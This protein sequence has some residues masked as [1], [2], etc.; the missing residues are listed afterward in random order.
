MNKYKDEPLLKIRN[1]NKMFY[2]KNDIVLAVNNV[3]FDLKKG[4]IMGLIGES[5]SG[6][7]TIGNS[8]IR[9][10]ENYSGFVSLDNVIISGKKLSKKNKKFL[11]KNMQM[12]FQ[13]PHASLNPQ[14]NI[15]SIL[16]EPLIINE[17]MKEEFQNIF[18]DWK[19]IVDNFNL[20]FNEKYKNTKLDNLI[21]M[22]KNHAK[23]INEWEKELPKINFND[24]NLQN[25]YDVFNDYML[26]LNSK[27]SIASVIV[28]TLFD[29][30][31]ALIDYFFTKQKEYRND[32]C[33]IDETNLK[34]TRKHLQLTQEFSKKSLNKYLLE[35][36]LKELRKELKELIN[37]NKLETKNT[38]YTLESFLQEFKYDY[39]KYYREAS[40]K[41]NNIEY[42]KEIWKYFLYKNVYQVFHKN[43][44]LLTSLKIFEVNKLIYELKE[45]IDNQMMSISQISPSSSDFAKNIKKS[46]KE[47]FNFPFKNFIEFAENNQNDFEEKIDSL[48]SR[49]KKANLEIKIAHSAHKTKLDVEK[50][51]QAYQNAQLEFEWNL[52]QYKIDYDKRIEQIELYIKDNL[53]LDSKLEKRYEILLKK[54][55]E[56]NEV[57]KKTII[58]KMNQASWSKI[59]I[60]KTLTF[61][62]QKIHEKFSTLKTFRIEIKNLEKDLE[63]ILYLLG[64]KKSKLSKNYIKSILTRNKI[65][66]ALEEVGLLRQFAWRYPHEFSGGQ[67][68]RIVIARA[69]ISKPKLIIADEPIASLDISIQAQ[70]VNLLKD[71]CKKKN[72]S[73]IF[74]AHDLSMVE[75]IADYINIMHLG[76]IVEAGKVEEIYSNPLHPYTKNLF[77]AIPTIA[78]A[79]KEFESSNFE[80]EYLEEQKTSP[81]DF[82]KL[83]DNHYIYGTISQFKKWTN[84]KPLICKLSN[85]KHFSDLDE[86]KL[87]EN[88]M[89]NEKTNAIWKEKKEKET[90]IIDL[91]KNGKSN[92]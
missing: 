9:L 82:F 22:N 85:R 65:Y 90:L 45:L 73:L 39:L 79:N 62:Q 63:Q 76:K 51:K 3:S 55:Q 25:M 27:Q 43:Y 8:L 81:A 7:T 41:T 11:Y 72:V 70:I 48:K 17:I 37:N 23:F 50:A 84:Q 4:E 83:N 56:I 30:N 59:K 71:L 46:I 77:N 6:K 13:D 54:F 52:K 67:R 24:L 26:F 53:E 2:S 92:T 69:L 80:T 34:E 18:L 91:T 64:I 28:K 74:V 19:L 12:I 35:K 88:D 49:I 38:L 75:Y 32:D 66:S 33:E 5:G 78:N 16:K 42:N 15:Y 31:S 21:T 40:K 36:E 14:K 20:S 10:Y 57:F 68:Q 89:D 87:D 61:F 58:E 44:R 60:N 1:L 29:N 86:L 47:N